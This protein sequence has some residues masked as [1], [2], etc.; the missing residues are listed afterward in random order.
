MDSFDGLLQQ[1]RW[2]ELDMDIEA[3]RSFL[4]FVETGSF[5]RASKQINRTQSAFSAQ[6][7]KLEDELCVSLFE[8]EGRNLVLSEAGLALRSHAEQLIGLHNHA[9]NQVKRYE[10]KRPLRLGCPEDYNDNILAKVI[11]VLQQANPTCS[12]QVI[13]EPSINLRNMLD[14]GKLDAAIITRAPG[15]EEGH[16]LAN[17]QGVWISHPEFEI[18]NSQ[19]LPITLFQTDCKYHAAAVD[20]LT[21][22]GISFQLLACCNTASAQR[23]I[24]RSK[25][26]VG[27][28]GSISVSDDL[29]ILDNMPPLPAV[30]IVLVT[31]IEPHPVLDKK[32]LS[33]L[34]EV[35]SSPTD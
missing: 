22:R 25:L 21:K 6:M 4:A 26:S 18:D 34:V 12:I 31:G 14:H 28:M 24:V 8:K 9:V 16:W 19:P 29:K 15:S 30:E 17:D 32:C 10:N 13:S 20:G 5:T 7:R 3:L 35:M 2:M 27:A 33:Q 23:A 1:K 11:S